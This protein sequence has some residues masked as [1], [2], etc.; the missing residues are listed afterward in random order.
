MPLGAYNGPDESVANGA[1]TVFPYTFKIFDETHLS[2]YLDDVLQLTGYTVSGVADES[3][4]NVTFAVAPANTVVVRRESSAPYVR[5]VDYQRNGAFD[6][7]TVDN[8]FD[9]EERQIQQ[10][11]VDVA[12]LY[13]LI[14]ALQAAIEDLAEI[15]GGIGT[16][17]TLNNLTINELLSVAGDI[18]VDGTTIF[19]GPVTFN[20]AVTLPANS[21]ASG[22][23]VDGTILIQDLSSEVLSFFSNADGGAAYSTI[24]LV[25]TNTDEVLTANAETVT[26]ADP[27]T[28]FVTILQAPAELTVNV[29]TAGP[30]AGGR[31]QAGAFTA[32]TWVHFYYIYNSTTEALA[33]I[34]SAVSP[35]VGP[36][37]PAGFDRWAYIHAVYFDALSDLMPTYIFGP[38]AF[39]ESQIEVLTDGTAAIATAVDLSTGMPPNALSCGINCELGLDGGGASPNAWRL[40]LGVIADAETIV[41]SQRIPGAA[42][43]G[44]DAW[45]SG[46]FPNVGQQLF[47]KVFLA[48]GSTGQ[49]HAWIFVPSYTVRN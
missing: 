3:G 34:A 41:L 22:N 39:H 28:G 15:A 27:S 33:A 14:A 44:T 32:E 49:G 19:N 9:L 47:Y 31:D 40:E 6:E 12:D 17:L 35:P 11:A 13:T 10:L 18:T 42:S 23:I 21:V 8:D 48:D 24:G 43:T 20:D 16:T 36:T 1:T 46:V 37:L 2:V 4:G 25:A 38:M 45:G 29:T 7:E 30:A 26:V 5:T